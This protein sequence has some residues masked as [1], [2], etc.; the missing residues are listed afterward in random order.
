MNIQKLALN[1]LVM[2]LVP[3]VLLQLSEYWMLTNIVH[4]HIELPQK[5]NVGDLNIWTVI[6]QRLLS[7]LNDEQHATFV[8]LFADEATF[9][10]NGW[11]NRR[12][13]HYYNGISWCKYICCTTF[14][15]EKVNGKCA[16]RS[17]KR[18]SDLVLF[19][20]GSFQ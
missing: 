6:C 10:S 9:H 18:F 17:C 8:I 11:A 3:L 14:G 15:S 4:Y 20:K 2:R 13:L 19:F 7:R 16:W 1:K 5:L 12:Y